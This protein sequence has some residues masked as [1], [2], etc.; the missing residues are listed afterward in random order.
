MT[1]E[2]RGDD[3]EPIELEDEPV[4]RPV[5]RRRADRSRASTRRVVVLAAVVATVAGSVLVVSHLLSPSS[6]ASRA[7]GPRP[8]PSAAQTTVAVTTTWSVPNGIVGLAGQRY[9][10]LINGALVLFDHHGPPRRLLDDFSGPLVLDAAARDSAL[11]TSPGGSTRVIVGPAFDGTRN[12]LPA[13]I[14]LVPDAFGRWWSNYGQL[15]AGPELR[16]VTPPSGTQLLAKLADG[17]IVADAR[18]SELLLWRDQQLLRLGV[19][20]A[21]VLAVAGTKVAWSDDVGTVVHV[22]DPQSGRTRD[23]PTGDFAL[24]AR[25]SPDL[26][27]I[28][29]FASAERDQVVLADATTGRVLTRIRASKANWVAA[30]DYL[31]SALL[32]VPFSW[33]LKSRQLLVVTTATPATIEW[34]DSTTG[35]TTSSTIAPSGL[36]QVALLD[37]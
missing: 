35:E 5:V 19:G 3:L 34:I 29:V 16:L 27:K 36:Q 31:P 21:R 22:A 33:T 25:F 7:R 12:V 2:H 13:A 14:V 11:V 23:I 37:S 4:V 28:A 30:P 10:A 24:T 9:L 6:R 18:R 8:T 15:S 17:Y 1:G 26:S 32:P 20:P